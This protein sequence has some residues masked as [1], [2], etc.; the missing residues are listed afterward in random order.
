MACQATLHPSADAGV[1]LQIE[2]NGRPIGDGNGS[3]RR[4]PHQSFDGLGNDFIVARTKSQEVG[5]VDV[6][7][8]S[9]NLVSSGVQREDRRSRDGAYA[10]ALPCLLD[11]AGRPGQHDAATVS[12][13]HLTL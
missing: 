10:G 13:T 4:D 1:V 5:A 12:Y 6:A 11:G 3:L 7:D 8:D 9:A 2:L